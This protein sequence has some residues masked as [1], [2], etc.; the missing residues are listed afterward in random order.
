MP[1]VASR[2]YLIP[3]KKRQG[4]GEPSKK[5]KKR[6]RLN[7]VLRR[8]S[9]FFHRERRA[10]GSPSKAQT[11]DGPR[12][13][14]CSRLKRSFFFLCADDAEAQRGE[15]KG[16]SSCRRRAREKSDSSVIRDFAPFVP[17]FLFYLF[18]SFVRGF[19]G[20]GPFFGCP[21]G[22]DRRHRGDDGFLLEGRPKVGDERERRCHGR[23]VQRWG[24]C[25]KKKRRGGAGTAPI[26]RG[27]ASGALHQ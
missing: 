1:T 26:R 3:K 16:V 17:F 19:V 4:Q 21:W 23:R 11:A 6:A 24:V 10:A 15:K 25:V 7:G 9:F 5:K 22:A 18:L 13:F 14:F 2:F 12:R 27:G 20:A 8:T